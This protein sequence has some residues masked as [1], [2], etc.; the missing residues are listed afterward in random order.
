M[1]NALSKML[2][3]SQIAVLLFGAGKALANF[4]NY[5]C[6]GEGWKLDV[7]INSTEQDKRATLTME[8][9]GEIISVTS[10]KVVEE[11]RSVRIEAVKHNSS[12]SFTNYSL[13]MPS[14]NAR[15]DKFAA[16][17]SFKTISLAIGGTMDNDPNMN[18]PTLIEM[19]CQAACKL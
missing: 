2:L 7:A 1:K 18:S 19:E 8:S 4:D 11:Q 9:D 16:Q 5:S 12:N 17:F 6:S 3:L 15:C 13:V 10:T 14:P